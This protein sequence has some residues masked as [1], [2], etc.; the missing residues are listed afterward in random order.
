MYTSLWTGESG[1]V[2]WTGDMER[3]IKVSFVRSCLFVQ[4][5]ANRTALGNN[6]CEDG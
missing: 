4:Q 5:R 3:D 2:K 6:K 1:E